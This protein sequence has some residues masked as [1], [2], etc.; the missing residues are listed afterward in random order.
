[1]RSIPIACLVLLIGSTSAL[2]NRCYWVNHRIVCDAGCRVVD[3]WSDGYQEWM[4]YSCDP[5]PEVLF[6]IAVGVIVAII[7]IIARI[8]S[9]SSSTTELNEKTREADDRAAEAQRISDR[10][11]AAAA[12]ADRFLGR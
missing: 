12:E 3:R 7:A 1:M 11:K 9:T 10:L 2:A 4:R 5:P 6:A 8:A